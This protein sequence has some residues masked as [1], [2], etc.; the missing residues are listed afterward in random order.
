MAMAMTRSLIRTSGGS[1]LDNLGGM[2]PAERTWAVP[3]WSPL[4]GGCGGLSQEVWGTNAP[5][6]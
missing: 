6:C 2:S 3:P 4:T 1:S 5:R